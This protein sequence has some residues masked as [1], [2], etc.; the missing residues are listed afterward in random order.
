MKDIEIA[1]K[2]LKNINYGVP[3]YSDL[4]FAIKTFSENDE[5]EKSSI[6]KEL[7]DKEY[8]TDKKYSTDGL[9]L[10][11][12]HKWDLTLNELDNVL[13]NLK[14]KIKTYQE[15]IEDILQE[16]D[17]DDISPE[18]KKIID[19]ISETA[20]SEL[21]KFKE[22]KSYKTITE[23]EIITPPLSEKYLNFFKKFISEL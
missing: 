3:F 21:K 23:P 22:I 8:F 6:I 14:D 2:I 13:D 15:I 7:L 1:N 16:N 11:P 10:V 17:T 4:E 18:D 20:K 12:I 19:N 9:E 5:F